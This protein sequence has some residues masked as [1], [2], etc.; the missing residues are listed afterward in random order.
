MCDFSSHTIS[1]AL[2]YRC[3]VKLC[4]EKLENARRKLLQ[5]KEINTAFLCSYFNPGRKF[6][7]GR[8]WSRARQPLVSRERT[9][10]NQQN[11]ATNCNFRQA[12]SKHLITLEPKIYLFFPK[13]LSKI[14]SANGFPGSLPV[15]QVR[16]ESYLPEGK[17]YLSRTNGRGFSRALLLHIYI[18][19]LVGESA[20]LA[21]LSLCSL[22]HTNFLID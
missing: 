4:T 15:G 7:R 21:P 8:F 6:D 11:N 16:R 12:S 20:F 3:W 14:Y 2:I 5:F 19:N 17:I 22:L 9:S 1:T 13:S 10:R 18:Q